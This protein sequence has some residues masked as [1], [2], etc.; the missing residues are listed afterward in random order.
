MRGISSDNIL[1][2]FDL[3]CASVYLFGNGI[4]GRNHTCRGVASYHNIHD[5]ADLLPKGPRRDQ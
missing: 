4:S 2:I 3:L 5:L 1:L